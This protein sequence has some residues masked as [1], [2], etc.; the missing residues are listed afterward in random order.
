MKAPGRVVPQFVVAAVLTLLPVA[1]AIVTV[2]RWT[3]PAPSIPVHWTTSHAD[4]YM[5]ATTVCWSGLALSLVCAVIAA[6]CAALVRSDS[7]RWGSA[8]GFG[9]LAAVGCAA[10][11][12][13]PVGQLTAAANTAGDPIG[14]AFLL[15]LIA[16]GWS[17]LVFGI[18]AT[19]R[20]DPAPD[21]AT[22]PDPDHDA[23]PHPA[24]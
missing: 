2:S 7:G 10:T 3:H 20:A 18:C 19:R 5:D 8:A 24:P 14:P 22:T 11:L 15:F 17:A 9:A 16:L 21:P 13:W 4:N 6:F 1:A 23:I 12:L